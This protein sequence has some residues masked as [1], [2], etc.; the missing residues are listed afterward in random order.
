MTTPPGPGRQA[1]AGRALRLWGR[2][3]EAHEQL[4]AAAQVL[5]AD[6]DTDTVRALDELATLSVH[7]GSPDADRLSSEALI[8]GQALGVGRDQLS[9]SFVTRG[10]FLITVERRPESVAYLHEAARLATQMGDI[11]QLGRALVNLS[12]A[13]A[14]TD[15]QA[16]AEAARTAA[17]HLRRPA[18]GLP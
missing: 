3:A 1:T 13:L 14:V 2:L 8:L 6:P 7:A 11:A 17:G 4:T 12:D 10:V 9:N 18:P 5:R 16:A 15:P